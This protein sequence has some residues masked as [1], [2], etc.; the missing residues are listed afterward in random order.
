[1][2]PVVALIT[3]WSF[4]GTGS[5]ATWA[6]EVVPGL[7]AITVLMVVY[8]RFRF[9]T[10]VYIVAVIHFLVLA[11]GGRYT[12]AES[13]IGFW[14]QDLLRL[15]RNPFD[16]VGHFMQGF[17]PA[18]VAREL[19]LRTTKLERGS[20]LRFIVVSICLAFSAF[21]ELLEWWWVILFYPDVGPDWL[22]H[23]GDPF[24]A[25]ADMLMAALG[26]SL[27]LLLLSRVQDRQMP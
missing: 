7:L 5:F 12:Y 25:Q 14:M 15:E 24:D 17:T 8:R 10:V 9:A 1:M 19:L 13:P 2:A 23:Q 11:I 16:R 22:G 21:Y 4:V 3:V 27:A 20:W 18:L 26:A 6:F